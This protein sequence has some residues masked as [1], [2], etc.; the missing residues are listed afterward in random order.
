MCHCLA[1]RPSSTQH[2]MRHTIHSRRT[3]GC[4]TASLNGDCR[5]SGR[6]VSTNCHTVSQVQAMSAGLVQ[7]LIESVALAAL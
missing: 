3:R 7:G 2:S 6:A 5:H 4:T 1:G